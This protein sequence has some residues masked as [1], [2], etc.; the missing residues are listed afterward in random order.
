MVLIGTAT[1]DLDSYMYHII[2]SLEKETQNFNTTITLSATHIKVS[3]EENPLVHPKFLLSIRSRKNEPSIQREYYNHWGKLEGSL[4]NPNV[5][6]L[7]S[8]SSSA[9][10]LSNTNIPYV[11]L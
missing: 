9:T 11:I 2:E 5:T 4:F 6:S 7:S 8:L 10:P 1:E 3:V